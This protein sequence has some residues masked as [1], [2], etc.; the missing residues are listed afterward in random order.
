[1][2]SQKIQKTHMLEPYFGK[3]FAISVVAIV[4]LTLVLPMLT[5]ASKPSSPSTSIA[6]PVRVIVR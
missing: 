2:S 1:M 3:S 5:P 6:N 4:M